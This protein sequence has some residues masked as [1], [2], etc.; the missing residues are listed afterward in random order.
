MSAVNRELEG[1][2]LHSA[3]TGGSPSTDDV[4]DKDGKP[5]VIG[6]GDAGESGLSQPGS[7]VTGE[8]DGASSDALAGIPGTAGHTGP[9]GTIAGAERK[10]KD[11][12]KGRDTDDGGSVSGLPDADPSGSGTDGDQAK[13]TQ[14]SGQAAI[15]DETATTF[16]LDHYLR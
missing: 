6:A 8:E 12:D 4:A 2:P 1:A 16:L 11:E 5:G 10:E 14:R 15:I 13:G 3:A 7:R 9:S